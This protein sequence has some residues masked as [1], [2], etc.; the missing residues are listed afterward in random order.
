MS[1]PFPHQTV[2][3]TTLQLYAGFK[4]NYEFSY[5]YILKM[6]HYSSS[7][8]LQYTDMT[9]L[10]PQPSRRL[11]SYKWQVEFLSNI[12]W[13]NITW[14]DRRTVKKSDTGL[15][16]A[17]LTSTS[18]PPSTFSITFQYC[19]TEGQSK[20]MSAFELHFNTCIN[21]HTRFHFKFIDVI[22]LCCLT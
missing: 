18:V 5:R 7:S 16:G 19:S 17:G 20:Q 8:A 14:C 15:W 3:H 9:V 4:A 21:K 6:Y 13:H 1:V 2:R 12:T 10:N 22:L 11:V